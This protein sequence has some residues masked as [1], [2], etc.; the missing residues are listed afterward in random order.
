MNIVVCIKQVPDSDKVTIDRETNR[1]N[2]AGVPSIINPFDENALEMAL[3]LKDKHGGKVTVISMGP[4][5]AVEAL[6]TALSHGAD[7][8]ILIS[9]RKF[10]GADTWATSYTISLAIKKLEVQP[11]IILFGKQAIDGDT[12]Q[13][14]PGV[15]HFLDLPM[16]TYAKAVEPT[17]AGFKV[18]KVTEDGYEIWEIDKPAAFTVVKEANQLR[19]PSLKKKMAAKKAEIPTWGFD[20]LN[21]IEEN[22]GL[23]G[24][25]TKVSKI[26][27]PPVKLNK[28]I[29]SGEPAEM[30]TELIQKLKERNV[31]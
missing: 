18:E 20:D 26:F 31:L 17:D 11:D 10:G 19:M 13:V 6:R 2:R 8:A 1:L 4:P 12:A 29:L 27:A 5:Q 7:D 9:D 28:E 23:A 15:A 25:P 24:S 22:I 21:P 16:L 14:G 30:I 3:Q